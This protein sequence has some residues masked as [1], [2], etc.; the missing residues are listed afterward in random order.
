LDCGFPAYVTTHEYLFQSWTGLGRHQTLWSEVDRGLADTGWGPVQKASLGE[1]GATAKAARATTI[2][3]VAP[4]GS[5]MLEVAVRG[6]GADTL[7][8]MGGGSIRSVPMA[9]GAAER[10]INVP[11]RS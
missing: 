11:I 1:I 6:G 2:F 9:A 8:I 7:T 10:T 4:A 3:S 5:G